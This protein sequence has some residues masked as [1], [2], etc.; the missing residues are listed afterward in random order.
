[1]S[2]LRKKLIGILAVLFCTLLL[3]STAIF[4]PK[5]SASAARSGSWTEIAEIYSDDDSRFDYDNL[6]KLYAA[7][8]GSGSTYDDV[9]KLVGKGDVTSE[10]IRGKNSGNNVSVWFGGKKWDVVFMTTVRTDS[11]AK[12]ASNK[13]IKG[14]IVVDL[15]Q[16]VDNIVNTKQQ[17]AYYSDSKSYSGAYPCSMYTTSMVRVQTLN[18][19]GFYS[20]NSTTLY[21]SNKIEP[22]PVHNYARFTTPKAMGSLAEYIV[23]PKDIKY[24]ETESTVGNYKGTN[25]TNTTYSGPNDAYGTPETENWASTNLNYK[26]KGSNSNGTSYSY[27]K[28]DYLWLASMAETGTYDGDKCNGVWKTNQNLRSAESGKNFWLRTGGTANVEYAFTLTSD[29]DKQSVATNISYYVRPALHLNLSKADEDARK[30]LYDDTTNSK[31]YDGA[32]LEVEILDYDKLT[33]EGPYV[34]TTAEY[35]D[36]DDI[37]DYDEDTG[38]FSATDANKKG[39]NYILKV[40]LKDGFVWEDGTKDKTR[41]YELHINLAEITIEGGWKALTDVTYGDSLLQQDTNK[42]KSKTELVEDVEFKVT[43][44]KYIVRVPEVDDTTTKNAP[45]EDDSGWK[46]ADDS[47]YFKANKKGTY[48]VWYRIEAKNFATLIGSYTVS[49]GSD[50][51]TVSLTGDGKIGSATYAST[52]DNSAESLT[53]QDWLKEKFAENVT[54]KGNSTEYNDK[55][56]VLQLFE[57]ETK[58][59][60]VL[61]ILKNGKLEKAGL[62]K[63]ERFDADTYYFDI[64]YPEGEEGS[65]A[66]TWDGDDRPTFTVEKLA[67]TVQI[68]AKNEG[69]E[70]KHTYGDEKGP[71]EM[72]YELIDELVKGETI[73]DLG[74][75]TVIIK[76]DD[77]KLNNTVLSSTTPVGKY[78]IEAKEV[79]INYDLQFEAVKYEVEKRKITLQVADEEIEYGK[80]FDDFEF[81]AMTRTEGS[82]ALARGDTISKLTAKAEYYLQFNGAPIEIKDIVIGEYELCAKAT[83]DNYEITILPGKMKVIEGN[84]DMSKVSLANAAYVHDGNPHPAEIKGDLPS[85]EISVSYVYV[86]M[87]DGSESTDAPVEIGLYLV[88]AKFT[89]NNSNYNEIS[90]KVAYIRIAATAEEAN[91]GFPSLPSDEEI[92]A[93]ADLAKKKK[94]AKDA[95]EKAADKKREEIEAS[96]MTEEERK[97]ANAEVDSELKKGNAAIDSAT[98]ES[99]VQSAESAAEKK[100]GDISTESPTKE[101]E[102]KKDAAKGELEDTAQKKRDEIDAS[103]M[104]DEEKAE[105]KKKVE[106]ELQKGKDAIDGATNESGVQSAENSAAA[107]IKNISTEPKSNSSFPWWIIAVAAGALLLIALIIIIVKRRQVADGE[108]E[109]DDFYG[110]EYYGDEGID[111]EY[112]D[113]DFGDNY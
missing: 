25:S 105:A 45:S 108:D 60:V 48:R 47:D 54:M 95:L 57:K 31:T 104:T 42:I 80:S 112:D 44:I 34:G 101:L 43:S 107:K 6:Q 102:K 70:L 61:Y 86:N 53:M 27:W 97:A 12:N 14:D 32:A 87:E 76:S 79:D 18:A 55:T 41:Y 2:K 83:Y 106:E 28:N 9:A 75:I 81:S 5:K 51:V 91:Q 33:I 88:Y 77:E 67:L 52:G 59:K 35:D 16:S 26:D 24:Q 100:I 68:V 19:G 82:P 40:T 63:Y 73:N 78:N 113:G 85:K 15:W 36:A 1:M 7:L 65:I 93:A 84:F 4:I 46:V 50:S 109:Y 98:N 62:N 110:D 29:G 89:H 3:L 11:N 103:D 94:A 13:D 38:V 30:V 8:A 90:D 111:E 72:T 74:E 66:F 71:V 22:E 56:A 49:V 96:E 10:D 20:K 92:E 21:N 64:E 99:G 58:L 39:E 69:D 37:A 17:Y 23:Q